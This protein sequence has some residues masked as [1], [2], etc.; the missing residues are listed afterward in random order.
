MV[1]AAN[2]AGSNWSDETHGL[3]QMQMLYARTV[4][5]L[6]RPGLNIAGSNLRTGADLLE[7]GS[8]IA[9]IIEP[10]ATANLALALGVDV[11]GLTECCYLKT[12]DPEPEGEGLA[13]AKTPNASIRHV[14]VVEQPKCWHNNAVNAS[15]TNINRCD[16]PRL[17]RER[18]LRK[19]RRHEVIS[20]KSTTQ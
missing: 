5:L 12:H 11:L 4:A 1:S 16:K 20:D 14:Y 17:R 15:G 19:S 3:S 6:R 7:K 2:V 18:R 9:H 13:V 10:L 8:R